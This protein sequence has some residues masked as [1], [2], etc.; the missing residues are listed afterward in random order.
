MA[1]AEN[2]GKPAGK[3]LEQDSILLDLHRMYLY[4]ANWEKLNT[5]D[6]RS[7]QE[8]GG[9]TLCAVGNPHVTLQSL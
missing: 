9:P 4:V 1:T 3:D 6:P 5:V 2:S 8:L 7:T